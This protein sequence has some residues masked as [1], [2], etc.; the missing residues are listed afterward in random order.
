[1]YIL[2]LEALFDRLGSHSALGFLGH[3]TDLCVAPARFCDCLPDPASTAGRE[4]TELLAPAWQ[5]HPAG[6]GDQRLWG[7]GKSLPSP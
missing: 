3:D 7:P 2:D 4:G 6:T 1:M 5:Q